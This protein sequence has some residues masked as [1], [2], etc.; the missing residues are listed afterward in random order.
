MDHP[1]P[2]PDLD[3][4][5]SDSGNHGNSGSEEAT[6]YDL[7]DVLHNPNV[8]ITTES[9]DS[10]ALYTGS[11]D[12]NIP[13]T[14]SHDPSTPPTE[15]RDPSTPPTGSHDPSTPPTGSH[16]PSTPPTG[17]HDPSTPPTESHD[18][19][20]PPTGSH[21]PSTPPTE[22]HDPS[23]PST[24]SHDPSTPP[25]GSHDPSTP[26]TGSHDSDIPL[27]IVPNPV[28]DHVMKWMEEHRKPP[29]VTDPSTQY[30]TSS[31]MDDG[32]QTVQDWGIKKEDE[33]APK[34]TISIIRTA[35]FIDLGQNINSGLQSTVGLSPE[36]PL[37][38]EELDGTPLSLL[39]L[40][41]PEQHVEPF[42][43]H[44]V[45]P[46][47]PDI[48]PSAPL[49]TPT[50]LDL[51]LTMSPSYERHQVVLESQATEGR[52]E[53]QASEGRSEGH[54]TEGSSEGQA[55]E[56]RS[57][58]HATEG[59]SEG[60]ATEGR[61]EGQASEGRSEGHATEGRSEGQALEGRSEGQAL[62]GRSEGQA[63]E[64]R[65]EG[66]ASEGRSEGQASEGRSEGQASEGRSEGQA[67]EGRSEGQASEGRSES[68]VAAKD[69]TVHKMNAGSEEVGTLYDEKPLEGKRDMTLVNRRNGHS[70]SNDGPIP[71][72][73]H[74]HTHGYT[75]GYTQDVLL[76][77]QNTSLPFQS[78]VQLEDQS[79]DLNAGAD[80]EDHQGWLGY[81][82][83][84]EGVNL[85]CS[86]STTT[87]Q[88]FHRST[89]LV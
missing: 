22:S 45:N 42:T 30:H 67:S 10:S 76:Q 51:G 36:P 3:V 50:K 8:P 59:R 7:E 61:S 29:D 60:H 35:P 11:H 13:P 26:P 57:E 54:A 88:V 46:L 28:P 25:T 34:D 40:H 75:H 49:L 68:D 9:H 77:P 2:V 58:G 37:E 83:K 20:T 66:Q 27:T 41:G 69:H 14:R 38:V 80:S 86:S 71:G 12:S 78:H 55:S 84:N 56:G 18:P 63:S 48:N 4:R 33:H 53:G 32:T 82:Y 39:K 65:S 1:P 72:H 5:A 19:S 21:D 15:S 23:T 52:S 43:A 17:S 74:G 87:E 79:H 89:T 64:G 24:G 44:T 16:D 81:T 31:I 85:M 73:T 6:G 47:V 62:E 70:V